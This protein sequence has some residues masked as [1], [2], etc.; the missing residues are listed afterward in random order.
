MLRDHGLHL[1]NTK[2]NHINPFKAYEAQKPFQLVMGVYGVE[3][4]SMRF[5]HEIENPT[6]YFNPE[7]AFGFVF[8]I[9]WWSTISSTCIIGDLV[10]AM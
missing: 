10:C 8:I 5:E 9:A 2:L 6:L 7:L 3:A 1:I 4:S